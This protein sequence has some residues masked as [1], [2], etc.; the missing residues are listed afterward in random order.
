MDTL[1]YGAD[2]GVSQELDYVAMDE[3]HRQLLA[4]IRSATGSI[5]TEPAERLQLRAQVRQA[6]PTLGLAMARTDSVRCGS[7][8]A[9]TKIIYAALNGRCPRS[10]TSPRWTLTHALLLGYLLALLG[11]ALPATLL[12]R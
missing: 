10:S 2:C 11:T 7:P 5:R 3:E 1:F 9:I 8:L 6:D 12:L 4:T